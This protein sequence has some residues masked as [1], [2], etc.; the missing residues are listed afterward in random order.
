MDNTASLGF[1]E[2]LFHEAGLGSAE[3][4]DQRWNNFI[5]LSRDVVDINRLAFVS[6]SLQLCSC[7]HCEIGHKKIE[8]DYC[9]GCLL[10]DVGKIGPDWTGC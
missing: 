8:V 6:F 5:K 3:T 7:C 2:I 9:P 10:E 4:F 1:R